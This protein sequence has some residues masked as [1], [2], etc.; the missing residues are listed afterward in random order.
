MRKNHARKLPRSI[1]GRSIE[2]D[3]PGW[4]A[5]ALRDVR[6]EMEI[7]GPGAERFSSTRQDE[8]IRRDDIIRPDNF[9]TN[10]KKRENME[11][12]SRHPGDREAF[13]S[14]PSGRPSR[15]KRRLYRQTWRN[16]IF[17]ASV[18]ILITVGLATAL[19]PLLNERN[20][21][22][23]PWLKT[24][25]VLIIGLS[26]IVLFFVAYMTQQQREVMQLQQRLEEIQYSAECKCRQNTD[27]LFALA[28]MSRIMGMETDI[29]KIFNAITNICVETFRADRASLMLCDEDKRFLVV[30][31]A[32]GRLA[33][34]L[35][36]MRRKIGE[37]VAG[38]VARNRK[39]LLLNPPLDMENY[40][41][42]DLSDPSLKSAMVTPIILR[43]EL[44]GVI[45]VSSQS[46]EMIYEAEDLEALQV[47]ADNAGLCIRHMEHIN[48]IK[49]IGPRQKTLDPAVTR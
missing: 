48:W 27:R 18:L 41:G 28:S 36:F 13:S 38:W 44:V 15:T 34:K 43:D 22:P 46:S 20:I 12:R 40:P 17:L 2:K 9:F 8:S 21:H 49:K 4:M 35:L 10:T 33:E 31:S 1:P 16:W 3:R 19:P 14:D 11:M 6:A 29:R 25:L 39:P 23:W 5:S 37:G 24:D 45:N 7:T 30:E 42:L 47:L 26:L 32:S